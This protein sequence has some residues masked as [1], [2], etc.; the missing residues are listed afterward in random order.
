MKRSNNNENK[1]L[2][3]E[4]ISRIKSNNLMSRSDLK[5][6]ATRRIDYTQADREKLRANQGN[7]SFKTRNRFSDQRRPAK[8]QPGEPSLERQPENAAAP[9]SS[10]PRN[11]QSALRGSEQTKSNSAES[12]D[13]VHADAPTER[14]TNSPKSRRQYLE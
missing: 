11:K 3:D 12:D 14:Q 5:E 6:Y 10:K 9:E 13:E 1:K 2:L 4:I 8:P 7:D